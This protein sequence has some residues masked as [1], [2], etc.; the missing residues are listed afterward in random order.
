MKKVN[1]IARLPAF[2]NGLTASL[3]FGFKIEMS[4]GIKLV[5]SPSE[6]D[7]GSKLSGRSYKSSSKTIVLR[8][9]APNQ[10]LRKEFAKNTLGNIRL[11]AV[12]VEK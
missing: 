10:T 2:L 11:R 1:K 9:L 5:T 8:W 4:H 12:P 6:E 7:H 3:W